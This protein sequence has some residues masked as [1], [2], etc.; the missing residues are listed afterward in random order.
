MEINPTQNMNFSFDYVEEIPEET[1]NT[2]SNAPFLEEVMYIHSPLS[3]GVNDLSIHAHILAKTEDVIKN[4]FHIWEQANPMISPTL[5]HVWI[6]VPKKEISKGQENSPNA[7]NVA[8]LETE[9]TMASEN[10]MQRITLT[11][12][13]HLLAEQAEDTKL[14]KTTNQGIIEGLAHTTVETTVF[15]DSLSSNVEKIDIEKIDVAENTEW[16][17]ILEDVYSEESLSEVDWMETSVENGEESTLVL[18]SEVEISNQA[19]EIFY[20]E[21]IENDEA[22][23]KYSHTDNQDDSQRI[24][25]KGK[26]KIQIEVPKEKEE[27]FVNLPQKTENQADENS[28]DKIIKQFL[29]TEP[30]MPLQKKGTESAILPS[31]TP[32]END[33]DIEILTETMA[34]IYLTQGN[35]KGAIQIYEKLCLLFPEKNTY[36]AD[37]IEKIKN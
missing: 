12:S 36:F 22:I 17:E 15:E 14:E 21:K 27:M 34:K 24:L 16:V 1:L 23:N 8:Q 31:L 10:E 7:E 18:V 33:E 13:E 37:Q 25:Y 2:T 3:K 9:T 4:A 6:D 30:K 29:M 5:E 19:E 11:N 32:I 26:Y 28:I 35:K 20:P